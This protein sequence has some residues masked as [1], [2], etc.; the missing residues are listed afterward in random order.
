MDPRIREDDIKQCIQVFTNKNKGMRWQ[1]VCIL[2]VHR[3][4][5]D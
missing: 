2:T 3:Q 5:F 1:T 4:G